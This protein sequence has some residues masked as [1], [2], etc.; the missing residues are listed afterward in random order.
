[1]TLSRQ[2]EEISQNKYLSL[3]DLMELSK[4][5][6]E[7]INLAKALIDAPAIEKMFTEDAK[8]LKKD[9]LNDRLSKPDAQDA[10]QNLEKYVENL[11]KMT[12]ELIE[13]FHRAIFISQVLNHTFSEVRRAFEFTMKGL[14]EIS[15][16]S[17]PPKYG[18]RMD[19]VVEE[20][21]QKIR[22]ITGPNGHLPKKEFGILH[23]STGE[24]IVLEKKLMEF[25]NGYYSGIIIVSTPPL[26]DGLLKILNKHE[27]LRIEE[28]KIGSKYLF[29]L[30]SKNY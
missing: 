26:K 20:I 17:S 24:E 29:V 18:V 28:R 11:P 25:L 13:T 6:R 10:L 15:N 12:Q 7:S 2:I 19:I 16:L 27:N 14:E 21:K 8:K 5:V 3:R 30:Q 4:I 23:L 22:N 1:M 9:Y